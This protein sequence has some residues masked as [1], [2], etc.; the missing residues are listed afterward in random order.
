MSSTTTPA[1][2]LTVTPV[3]HRSELNAFIRMPHRLYVGN[4]HWT[5]PL[6]S[7]QRTLLDA[8]RGHPFHEFARV[9][10]FLARRGRDVVGRIAAVDDCRQG[11]GGFGL[12]ESVPDAEV[13]AALFVAASDWLRGRGRVRMLGPLNLSTNHECGLLVDGFDT[14][15]VVQMPYNPDYYQ[16]LFGEAGLK[17]AKDLWSWTIDLTAPLPARLNRLRDRVAERHRFTLR[18]LDLDRLDD[19]AAVLHRI[20]NEAW[21]GNWGFIPMSEAE[22]RHALGELKPLLRRSFTGVA[23]IDGVPVAFGVILPDAAPALRAARGRLWRFG[24][25]LGALRMARALRRTSTGRAL[26]IGVLDEYRGQ[27]IDVLLRVAGLEQARQLGMR[28]VD[29]SWVLED[30]TDSNRGV[31]A[32]GGRRSVTHRLYEL[33]L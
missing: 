27:G 14:P 2:S 15:P 28:T 4:P 23:E 3:Q 20:Y 33:D 8:D 30:N 19:E 7:S 24:F 32:M 9:Q 17:P 26:L 29:A 11:E 21:Q 5:P 13:C 12:F 6:D 31:V 22:F 1:A 10:P 25:P 18:P 16:D